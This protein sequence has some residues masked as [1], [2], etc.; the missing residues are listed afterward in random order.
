M[1]KG[2][3]YHVQVATGMRTYVV[4]HVSR[5]SRRNRNRNVDCSD[6][7]T[8]RTLF[9]AMQ[10]GLHFP[11][12]LAQVIRIVCFWIQNQCININYLHCTAP[13]CER[14]LLSLDSFRFFLCTCSPRALAAYYI[15]FFCLCDHRFQ[16]ES[17]P[18]QL[19]HFKCSFRS[20]R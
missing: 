3:D 20:D 5:C 14:R 6:G 15:L 9:F 7:R 1:Q 12:P 16:S 13:R 10:I 18:T 4:S 11:F 17:D 8:K 2:H 19:N